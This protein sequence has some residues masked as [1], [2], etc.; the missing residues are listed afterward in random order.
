MTATGI[1]FEDNE[2]VLKLDRGDVCT[3]LN[4]LENTKM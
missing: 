4:I 2:N 3:T 1:S